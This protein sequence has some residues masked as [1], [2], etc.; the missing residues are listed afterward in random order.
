[1]ATV[2]ID[3]AVLHFYSSVLGAQSLLCVRMCVSVILATDFS[4]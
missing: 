2:L 4:S 1:M 3:S